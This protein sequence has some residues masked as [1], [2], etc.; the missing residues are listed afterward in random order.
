MVV[1]F[2]FIWEI[3]MSISNIDRDT[4]AEG[5][6]RHIGTAI[7][8]INTDGTWAIGKMGQK[9]SEYQPIK[10]GGQGGL[11]DDTFEFTAI[12]AEAKTGGGYLLYLRSNDNS[13]QFVE[14]ELDANG[15]V[16]TAKVM[17]QQEWFAAEV[18]WNT[19]LNDNGGL[20]TKMVLVDA[21]K[22]NLYVDGIGAY[23][24][25]QADKSF[26]PLTF[27][28]QPVTQEVLE[29]GGF[30]IESVLPK[31]GGGYQ[32]YV[33]D[34]NDNV[35]ELG[36]AEDGEV[37]AATLR[38]LNA[39][40]LAQVETTTGEDLNGKGDTTAATDWT[41]TL[42]TTAIRTE[43]ETQTANGQKITQAGLVKIVNAAI[44][45]V[46]GGANP[47]GDVVFNDLKAI[48]ARGKELFTNKNLSA[49]ET[50]YLTYVFDKMVNGSKANNF[51]TGGS[52]QKQNLDNLSS[53]AT[54]D[55]LQ[56]LENKWLLGLDLPNPKT[57]GDT[58]NSNAT[59]AS[60][61]YKAFNA[62]LM[63]GG[64]T[65]FDVN[66]GSAGTCYLMA[67]IASIAQVNPNALNSTFVSNG[68]GADGS[69][70]WGVR[71][72]DTKGDAHWVTVNNQLVVRNA[73]D[74]NAAYAQV[75]GVNAQ[76]QATQELWAPLIEKA[77]AQA[78]ELDIFA[79]QKTENA[80]FAVEG[81]LADSIVNVAGGKVT[82]FMDRVVRF[83]G[84]D[85]LRSS[86]VPED[87]TALAEYTKALNSGKMVWIGSGIK[88]Q[89]ANGA[90]QFTGG[91]AYMAFDADPNSSTN[92]TV[93]V[94][95]PWGASNGP[96]H[97]TPFD[98]DLATLVGTTGLDFWISL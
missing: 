97:V 49:A 34:E 87:S 11:H 69:P 29:Q 76:G 8:Y 9:V 45:S 12:S 22:V 91:H 48:A 62:E 6:A 61:V 17:T 33:R 82:V 1:R 98:G 53:T 50:D 54:A 18:K 14:A 10:A 26:K 68:V 36:S 80:M 65:A 24:I 55:T 94:Y 19:D 67:A 46:G 57:E 71:F 23:Q 93:K 43:V 7:L 47:I 73:D 59:A 72:F 27:A 39:T 89:D 83:N 44:Q 75:K 60:G 78:N 41:T 58:A 70:T 92:T 13:N 81:G 56:K 5:H 35:I 30:A 95:N 28:G 40:Q 90:T 79:R 3:F 66:Q 77:Y 42:K 25:Q 38:P 31:T 63:V 2:I 20:G 85:L 37:Q 15:N 52:T 88:T 84:N 4:S 96:S 86:A 21:G 74:T 51:Y 16:T 32:I 64:A